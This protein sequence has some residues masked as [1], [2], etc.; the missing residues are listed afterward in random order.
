MTDN[1]PLKI[2]K[3]NKEKSPSSAHSSS[4]LDDSLWD[5]SVSAE[6]IWDDSISAGSI[7]TQPCH[8]ASPQSPVHT[9]DEMEMQS[10]DS[11][12]TEPGEIQTEDTDASVQVCQDNKTRS[13]IWLDECAELQSKAN[14]L[15][16]QLEDTR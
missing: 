8:P 7:P 10:D 14:E 1:I 15:L 4:G 3:Q 11:I 2:I 9:S 5:D 12:R 6:S 16:E 13:Q